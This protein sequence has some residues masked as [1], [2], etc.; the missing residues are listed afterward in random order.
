VSE[1]PKEGKTCFDFLG[2]FHVCR[3]D[4]V[5]IKVARETFIGEVDEV[6]DWGIV[7]RD[8][9]GRPIVIRNKYIDYILRLHKY[10]EDGKDAV[11]PQ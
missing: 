1:E 4:M 6:R 3:G 10:K 9:F 5:R 7:I 8:Q 2:A 11:R